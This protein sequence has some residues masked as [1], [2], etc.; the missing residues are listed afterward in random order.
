MV[1]TE[2]PHYFPS[3]T[4]ALALTEMLLAAVVVASGN[5]ALRRIAAFERMQREVGFYWDDG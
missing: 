2:S 5:R 4:P 3:F 1:P